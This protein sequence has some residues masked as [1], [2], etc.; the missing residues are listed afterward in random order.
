MIPQ[1]A[2]LPPRSSDLSLPGKNECWEE[3]C[4]GSEV[5]YQKSVN[6]LSWSSAVRKEDPA[7]QQI[8]SDTSCWYRSVQ[9]QT[10]GPR[11]AFNAFFGVIY[12]QVM[13]SPIAGHALSQSMQSMDPFPSSKEIKEM[14][15]RKAPYIGFYQLLVK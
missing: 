13:T 14:V 1:C 4:L 9:S 11:F 6:L 8:T 2:H 15:S 12:G 7:G 5:L 3:P 10:G